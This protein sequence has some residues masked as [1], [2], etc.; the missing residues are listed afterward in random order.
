MSPRGRCAVAIVAAL[1][2]LL[3]VGAHA[4]NVP[5]PGLDVRALDIYRVTLAD[6][7][8]AEQR[9]SDYEGRLVLLSISARHTVGVGDPWGAR[10]TEF[11]GD[12]TGD[13][14]RFRV[15]DLSDV[16]RIARGFARYRLRRAWNK[17]HT[18]LIDWDGAFSA[19]FGL[20]LRTFHI[21][22][23]DPDGTVRGAEHGTYTAAKFARAAV[24][25]E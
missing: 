2:P 22:V 17:G 18:I 16:P 12:R 9:L 5:P 1:L 25:L 7:Y 6:V 24:L 10:A 11:L 4:E 23:C 19:A 3:S 14:V 13:V 8:G 15:V 20:D 21:V